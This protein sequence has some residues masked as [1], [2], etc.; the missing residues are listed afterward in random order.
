M[1]YLISWKHSFEKLNEEYET[2]KKKKQALDKLM[3][4]KKISQSTYDLFSVEI[5]EAIT[6]I[7]KQQKALFEKINAKTMELKEQIR[8]LE[9]LLAN[10][11]I[12]HVTGEI[13][14]ETYQQQINIISM[15][16]ETSRQELELVKQAT[17]TLSSGNVVEELETTAQNMD[18]TENKEKQ[19]V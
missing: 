15:G 12:Q 1:Q 7:E 14:E 6:D 5:A 2:A 3:S 4:A 10:F 11:E 13:N 9:I 8:T 18:N 19:K 16:L 17:E